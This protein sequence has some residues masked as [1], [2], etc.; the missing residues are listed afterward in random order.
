M[1]PLLRAILEHLLGTEDAK[2][3]DII[4]N[5]AQINEDGSFHIIYRH[6]ESG[7]GHDKSQAII[8][9]RALP[10]RPTIF[11]FG[12][13]VSDM[14]AAVHADVLFVK[15]DKPEGHNDLAAY[16]KREGIKH[17]LF[18]NFHEAQP[19]VSA[20]VEGQS[21]VEDVLKLSPV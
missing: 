19:I 4:S 3:I 16:C 13:G 9:Y 2:D 12:D 14:S 5:S 1:E 20:V 18:K 11:F 10:N 6:P 8:P 17:I 15:D 7:F 21:S